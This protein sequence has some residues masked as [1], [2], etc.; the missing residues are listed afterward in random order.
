MESLAR[1]AR[2]RK[3]RRWTPRSTHRPH[4]RRGGRRDLLEE[5]SPNA[6]GALSNGEGHDHERDA[7]AGTGARARTERPATAAI[8]I[9]FQ[10]DLATAAAIA[11]AEAK[12]C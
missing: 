12:A 2:G 1:H 6:A 4:S 7:Q 10:L 8:G 3:A 11:I 9:S 5:Q